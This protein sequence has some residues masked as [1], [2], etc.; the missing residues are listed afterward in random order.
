MNTST[1]HAINQSKD[2]CAGD[3]DLALSL[4]L[5]DG[6]GSLDIE[7]DANSEHGQI[8]CNVI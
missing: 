3:N 8:D 6:N 4:L 5:A 2:L 1:T 7:A